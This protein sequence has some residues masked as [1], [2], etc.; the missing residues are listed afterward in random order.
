MFT[1]IELV[2]GLLTNSV[3][4]MADAVHDLGDSVTLS[5]ALV[6][7]RVAGRGRTDRQTFGYRRYSTLGSL[8]TGMILVVGAVLV[9]VHAVPRIVEPQAVESRGMI[10][11]AVLGVVMNVLAALRLSRSSSMNARAAFL[12]L[13]EDVLGWVAVLVGAI[14]I[15]IWGLTWLDPVLSVGINLFVLS[16]AIPVL[17]RAMRVF[18]QYVPRELSVDELRA[19]VL[20]D[21][22]VLDVHDVHLWTL[23]GEYR[24]FSGHIVTDGERTLHQLEELKHDIRHTLRDAGVQHVTVEFEAAGAGCHD[25]DL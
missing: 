2:G 16:R 7:E 20:A 11:L 17:V 24:L 6:M 21:E 4:I 23:D 12:H 25:C 5:L 22:R 18:L 13:T 3:A 19:A 1:V 9:L 14:A 10:A 15:R 8:F